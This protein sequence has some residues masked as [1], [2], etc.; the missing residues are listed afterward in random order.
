MFAKDLTLTAEGVAE[1]AIMN[2]QNII[3][4]ELLKASIVQVVD[5][6]ARN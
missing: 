3:V 1:D 5:R 4:Q 6:F 2:T